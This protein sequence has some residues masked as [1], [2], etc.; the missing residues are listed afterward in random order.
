MGGLLYVKLQADKNRCK[1]RA[2]PYTPLLAVHRTYPPAQNT[3]PLVVAITR[4]VSLP[5]NF[6]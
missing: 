1:R 4:C 6:S 5:V 2:K 3:S